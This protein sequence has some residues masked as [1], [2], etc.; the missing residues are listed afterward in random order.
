MQRLEPVIADYE[1]AV[2]EVRGQARG[3]RSELRVGYLIS[4]AQSVLTPALNRFRKMHPDVKLRL[5][6][7]SPREQIEA[8]RAGEIDVALIG[9]DGASVSGEFYST[10]LASLGVCAALADDDPLASKRRISLKTLREHD[11][12]GV[13]EKEAPGRNRWMT[14]ICRK[15]GFRPWVTAKIDGITHIL[16]QVAA[17]SA[18]TLLPSFFKD[19]PH[20]EVVFVPIAEK[21]ARWEFNVLWQRGKI[22]A[23][24]RALLAALSPQK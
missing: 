7:M 3:I 10:K 15:A 5:H 20:T 6:D 11:F 4:A 22:P 17:E 23:T 8:L 21:E 16:S 1:S 2:A 19:F 9:Q 12:I 24:T 18:T 14:S 13:D